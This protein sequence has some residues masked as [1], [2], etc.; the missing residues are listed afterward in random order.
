MHQEPSFFQ[1]YCRY[2][3]LL[4]PFWMKGVLASFFIF[5]SM[6][7]QIPVPFMIKRIMDEF[8]PQKQMNLLIVFAAM[9]VG[10]IVFRVLLSAM[11]QKIFIEYKTISR[12]TCE[13]SSLI[14]C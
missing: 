4:K 3:K 1:L 6:L 5:L 10:L 12:F 13:T 11:Q 8:V 2:M 14:A 9:I 7:V